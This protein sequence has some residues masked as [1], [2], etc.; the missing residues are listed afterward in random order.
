MKCL[1]EVSREERFKG[2]V[3][4]PV[5]REVLATMHVEQGH[6]LMVQWQL[7]QIYCDIVAAHQQERWDQANVLLAM[8]RLSN[9]TCRKLGVGLNRDPGV[10]LFASGEAQVL[11]LKET[12][13]AELEIIIEDN[14]RTP[15]LAP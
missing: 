1:E 10:L 11:G 7:P 8:V 12:A 6:Q 15:V 9:L 5:L 3:I 2:G 14:A 13:L 4:Q